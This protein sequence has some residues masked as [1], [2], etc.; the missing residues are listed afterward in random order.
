MSDSKS[1]AWLA[2]RFGADGSALREKIP[3]LLQAC[4][5]GMAGAQEAAPVKAQ[6]VYGGMSR[7][8]HEQLAEQFRSLPSAQLY[9]PKGAYYRLPVV[10]GTALFPRRYAPTPLPS[11]TGPASALRYRPPAKSFSGCLPRRRLAAVRRRPG[12]A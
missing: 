7:S 10:N 4:H 11:P 9:H 8:V 3:A 2:E 6:V 1:R 5:Q 12:R